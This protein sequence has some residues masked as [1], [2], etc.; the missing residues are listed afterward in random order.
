[1]D[2]EESKEFALDESA[3][4]LYK[5]LEGIDQSQRVS[6]N[7]QLES[8]LM[9]FLQEEEKKRDNYRLLIA[10]AACLFVDILAEAKSG[11]FEKE[12]HPKVRMLLNVLKKIADF[13]GRDSKITCRFRGQQTI[14]EAVGAPISSPEA[15]DY[16][17]SM[18][19]ILLDYLVARKVE[20]REPTTGKALCANLLRAFT[21]LSDLRI[22]NFSIYVKTGE[23][24]EYSGHYEGSLKTLVRFYN[25]ENNEDHFL[26]RDE[27][28]RPN[29][30]LTLLAA[31]NNVRPDSLQ[32]L[33][34]KIKPRLSG[35][36]PAPELSR[37]TT[38]YDVILATKSYQRQ[39]KK[40]PIEVNNVHQLML[41]SRTNSQQTFEAVQVSRL[42]LAQYGGDPIKV[43]ELIS[44]ISR[45]GYRNIQSKIM[46]KRLSL[47]TEFFDLAEGNENREVLQNEALQNIEE[48]LQNIPD[49]M[50]HG[51]NIEDDQISSVDEEGR[52]NSWSLHRK[53][54][55]LVGYFK[56]RA[57]TKIKV[58]E[59]NKK[60]VEFDA[61]DYSVIARNCKV[62]DEEA[63]HLVSL[64]KECFSE[65]G[66]FRRVSFEKNIP[67]FLKYEENVFEFL[68]FYLKELENK[69]D[70]IALLNS[71]QLLVGQL[72]KP[73]KVMNILLDDIFNPTSLMRFSDRNGL[74]LAIVLLRAY[75][76][77][78]GINIELTPEEVLFVRAGLNQE[79]VKVATE[80]F[81][82]NHEHVVVKVKRL[83]EL[84]LQVSV[85]KAPQEEQ[86]PLRFLI[87]LM[88]E[89][90]IFCALIGGRISRFTVSGV[91]REFGNPTSSFYQKV[92]DMSHI[93]R[94][95]KLLQ[96]A[97]RGLKRFADPL[98]ADLL[99]SIASREP[100]FI[101]L[102]DN[103]N[104]R[105]AVKTIME[106]LCRMDG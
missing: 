80:F 14:R 1:M 101:A 9:Q 103:P 97:A 85:K 5:Q 69:E 104:H 66:R 60:E 46:G 11:G 56:Q 76:K 105:V 72:N 83:T 82:Y 48:G 32:Q 21:T 22:F 4:Q 57:L 74:I 62:T 102:Y 91:V 20:E 68:W 6:L 70:R 25:T 65:I 19:D 96:V 41:R 45:D 26:V 89:M 71:I 34:D 18:G 67:G 44:S 40:M 42:V 51:L 54:S 50:Y 81:R 88:R 86:M 17:L 10:Q 33:V 24:E 30:N 35:P 38:A 47:A 98:S 49:E 90:V 37:F 36:D 28:G 95:L 79:I 16:E 100:E 31:T 84:L 92:D 55:Q 77:E 15:Y 87:Y 58:R 63:E 64:L 8:E 78:G 61:V 43:S 73:E 52:K 75:N 53:V 2:K 99:Q 3:Q 7:L 94:G 39:L 59:I 13:S 29:I 12:I 27:Y 93:L 106:Q 23:V